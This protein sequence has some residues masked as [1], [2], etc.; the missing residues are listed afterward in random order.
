MTLRPFIAL[1]CVLALSAASP[2]A[3]DLSK[4]ASWSQPT[5]AATKAQLDAW[6]ADKDLDEA[7]KLKVDALWPENAPADADLLETT[8]LSIAAVDQRARDLVAACQAPAVPHKLPSGEALAVLR[9]EAAAPLVRNNLR[10]LYGRWL[11]QHDLFDEALEQ[12]NDLK[13]EDVVDPASL[14]FYQAVAHHRLRHKEP[15]L[16]AASKLLENE[17][18]LPR[19]YQS[20][21]RLMQADMQPL[22]PDSLDEIARIMDSVRIRLAH[23]RA[24]K[25]VRTEED[26]VIAKLDKLIKD[27]EDQLQQSQQSGS[28]GAANP[29]QPAQ[30]SVPGG[31]QGPGEVD[32][33]RIGEGS[34]W[35]NLPAKERQ[36]TLQQIAKELPA[37]YRETIQEYFRR[38]AQDEK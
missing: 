11:A 14:L 23:G 30:D 27:L 33:K 5:A 16:E 38:L 7:A 12:L 24:G 31:V 35:G 4:R 29:S 8:A 36:E 34:D 6:L 17:P 3:D 28:Q 20:L 9:D 37:H 10:L 2:A 15:C 1:G 13:T 25:R 26:E 21:A 19:R 18:T 22:K 32:Q